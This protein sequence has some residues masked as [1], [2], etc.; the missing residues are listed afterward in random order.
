[1]TASVAPWLQVNP[2]S[3]V[4]AAKAGA[5]IGQR[6][7]ASR[8][9][10]R[11]ALAEAAMR[12]RAAM[13]GIAASQAN[14]AAE[15]E[16]SKTMFGMKRADNAADLDFRNRELESR[17][18]NN[19]ADNATRLEAAKIGAVREPGKFDAFFDGLNSPSQVAE[20]APPIAVPGGS[21]AADLEASP[22]SIWN[23]PMTNSI[24]GMNVPGQGF[25]NSPA[26]DPNYSPIA[27]GVAQAGGAVPMTAAQAL[28]PGSNIIGTEENNQFSPAAPRGN[29]I[30]TAAN[31]TYD[32]NAVQVKRVATWNPAGGTLVWNPPEE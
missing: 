18:A 24:P 32:P 13:A 7:G 1:M 23:P 15:L 8:R 22:S 19:A 28:V 31:N 11:V 26:A 14:A 12:Q 3:F 10:A 4:E 21:A 17:T 20:P 5:D 9:S 25:A 29:I 30:G 16:Q 27:A 2:L 6:E